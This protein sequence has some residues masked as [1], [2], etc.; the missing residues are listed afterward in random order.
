[1]WKGESKMLKRLASLNMTLIMLFMIAAMIPHSAFAED[2]SARGYAVF[3]KNDGSGESSSQT[4]SEFF[5]A[6]ATNLRLY[7]T[8]PYYS[9]P[10]RVVVSYNSEPDGTGTSYPLTMPIAGAYASSESLKTRLYAIW[11]DVTEPYIL[12]LNSDWNATG[13]NAY[14]IADGLSGATVIPGEEVFPNPTENVF[15]WRTIHASSGQFLYAGTTAYPDGGLIM[16]SCICQNYI[17]YHIMRGDAPEVDN[18]VY[19]W[20]EETELICHDPGYAE[21]Q[22]FTGWN[23][24]PDGT[25]T[26]FTETESIVGAPHDLYAIYEE[27][28]S[29]D[30]ITLACDT[31]LASGKMYEPVPLPEDGLVTLPSELK[32]AQAAAWTGGDMFGGTRTYPCGIPMSIPAGTYLSARKYSAGVA[33]MIDGNGGKTADGNTYA[34]ASN[35]VTSTSTLM[36]YTFQDV[37]PFFKENAVLVGYQGDRT[38][39]LYDFGDNIWQAAEN[40]RGEGKVPGFTA[41]YEDC[42]SASILYLGNGG[43]TPEGKASAWQAV[44]LKKEAPLI[45][46]PFRASGKIFDGWMDADGVTYEAGSDFLALPNTVLYAKWINNRVTYH[47][48]VTDDAVLTDALYID[49]CGLSDHPMFEGWNDKEDGSGN[50]YLPGDPVPAGKILDLY[51]QYLSASGTGYYYILRGSRMENGHLAQLYPMEKAVETVT[52]PDLGNLGWC[53]SGTFETLTMVGFLDEADFCQA[54][55]PAELSSGMI[56]TTVDAGAAITYHLNS[57]SDDAQRV[58]YNLATHSSLVVYSPGEVFTGLPTGA[59]FRGWNEE[60]DGSGVS[61]PAGSLLEDGA[62]DLYAQWYQ[63]NVID[64]GYTFVSSQEVDLEQHVTVSPDQAG[65]YFFLIDSSTTATNLVLYDAGAEPVN[66]FSSKFTEYQGDSKTERQFETLYAAYLPAGEQFDLN[67]R[68]NW[69]TT[70]EPPPYTLLTYYAAELPA[71]TTNNLTQF[72]SLDDARVNWQR[73]FAAFTPAE[74]GWYRF[75]APHPEIRTRVNACLRGSE[76]IYGSDGTTCTGPNGDYLLHAGDTYVIEYLTYSS[77]YHVWSAFD[78]E[79]GVSRVP[80]PDYGTA[81][82]TATGQYPLW[83]HSSPKLRFSLTG[84]YRI[85]VDAYLYSPV[86]FDSKGLQVTPADIDQVND[87]NTSQYSTTLVYE[88]NA[89]ESY[90]LVYGSSSYDRTKTAGPIFT[91]T[92]DTV[93][94]PY[95]PGVTLSCNPEVQNVQLSVSNDWCEEHA[96][97]KMVAAIYE[98]GRLVKCMVVEVE[99]GKDFVLDLDYEGDVIPEFKLFA[100]DD[101]TK[102]LISAFAC[103]LG[104]CFR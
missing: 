10:G 31:G 74:S 40:E 67:I 103:D 15:A 43:V 75:S 42:G 26:W 9:E 29:G 14:Q 16:L 92:R 41:M 78:G 21:G 62:F 86:L 13:E 33:G 57:G 8:A 95:E 59:D 72:R 93:E 94:I 24:K 73:R 100:L 66:M 35:V 49:T 50:W 56:L 52:L 45:D 11:E 97:K 79:Y 68:K 90:Y 18:R 83:S 91:V 22:M 7:E 32:G 46:N 19:Y 101:A 55:Q 37:G 17:R 60:R 23:S 34:L 48:Y 61:Y 76:M 25:G 20:S 58:S 53:P 2:E 87:Y 47:L 96:V 85:S 5:G 65:W 27:C 30:Y 70:K 1:M 104:D 3:Y 51:P 69:S 12:Y 77:I 54:G 82:M 64:N 44:E 28:P 71:L 102:P 84:T 38:E 80:E 39:T 88:L 6:T 36:I 98:N 81:Q 99:D 89:G 63:H 4:I